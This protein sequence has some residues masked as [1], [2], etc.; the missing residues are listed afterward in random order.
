MYNRSD[1]RQLHPSIDD[2]QRRNVLEW[3]RWIC[4]KLQ[5]HFQAETFNLATD[6]IDRFM[7]SPQSVNRIA[8]A[9]LSLIGIASLHNA[10]KIVELHSSLWGENLSKLTDASKQDI[11]DM[12]TRI[13]KAIEWE[14]SS[15]SP[16]HFLDNYIQETP[17][18]SVL[19]ENKH[20][21][22]RVTD[23]LAS[24]SLDMGSLQFPNSLIAQ[25]AVHHC[26]SKEAASAIKY[27]TNERLAECIDWINEIKLNDRKHRQT[28]NNALV[29][30][31]IHLIDARKKNAV[32][33]VTPVADGK[34]IYM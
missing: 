14:I 34:V 23:L 12:G 19:K 18:L 16:I 21:Y 31:S 11:C 27:S 25:A 22:D 1:Y 33:K 9:D 5:W 30:N 24:A 6:F 28:I 3:L 17:I 7:S 2:R 26:V 4:T 32:N 29:A 20:Q 10:I 15:K 8:A 13:L